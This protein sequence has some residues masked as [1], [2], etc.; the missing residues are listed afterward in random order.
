MSLLGIRTVL[1]RLTVSCHPGP[2]WRT[3]LSLRG[4]H[5]SSLD[6]EAKYAEKLRLRA[7]Q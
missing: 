2:Y 1:R 6:R 5:D 4:L 3:T 7:E